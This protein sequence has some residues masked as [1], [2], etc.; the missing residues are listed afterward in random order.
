MN[1]PTPAGTLSRHLVCDSYI[2]GRRLD[3]ARRKS[4]SE[5]DPTSGR[6]VWVLDCEQTG[7]APN[8]GLTKRTM[9]NSRA[10]RPWHPVSGGKPP[11]EEVVRCLQPKQSP[12]YFR[13]RLPQP[14]SSAPLRLGRP[15][16][17]NSPRVHRRQ[18]RKRSLGQPRA[19]SAGAAFK[20][21]DRRERPQFLVAGKLRERPVC[22]RIIPRSHPTHS[23]FGTRFQMFSLFP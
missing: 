20:R 13:S 3:A 4:Y 2:R 11:L 12:F 10:P 8:L 7:P 18:G 22:P 21:E 16:I 14:S 19:R 23:H 5:T 9:V 1:L 6:G 15:K 17:Q